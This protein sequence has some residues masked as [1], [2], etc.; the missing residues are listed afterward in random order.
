MRKFTKVLWA[1]SGI[2]FLMLTVM[3]VTLSQ[4][5]QHF[6]N[7]IRGI[8]NASRTPA[9]SRFFINFTQLFNTNETIIWMVIVITLSW[10][11]V[12]RRFTCQVT[13][14]MVTVLLLNRIIKELIQRPRPQTDLLMHYS[15]Y[16]FPSGHSSA[17]A[18]ICGC[19]ILLIWQI[20]KRRWAQIIG[21][22][23]LI[24]IPLVIGYSRIYVGA[25]FPSDVLAG[26]CLGTFVLSSCQLFFNQ[27]KIRAGN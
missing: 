14:S 26:W 4:T 24:V 19:L 8:V 1:V 7:Q 13:V 15:N 20:G 2:I 12:N 9:L 25:H 11:M 10:I 22:I 6:D 3:M 21:T 23:L 16:S 5:V 17:S 18:V 27:L